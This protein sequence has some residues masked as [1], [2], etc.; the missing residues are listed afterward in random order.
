MP[1]SRAPRID[2]S[3]AASISE[4]PTGMRIL[5]VKLSSLGDVVHTLPV[6]QDIARARPGA[7]IEWA[8]EPAFA[9]LVRRAAGIGEV[10][11][12]PLRRW[13]QAW[14]TKGVRAEC[15]ALRDRLRAQRYDAVIDLQGLTKSALVAR[16]ANGPRYG[17][18][19]A[20]DGS[21]FEW[22]A[23]WLVDR[24]ISVPRRIHALDR[25]RLVAARALGYEV[26]GPPDF[27]LQAHPPRMRHE[28]HTVAFVH[29]SSRDDKL[30]PH[31]AWVR[32]G[33][34]FTA[35]GW[36]IALPQ[37]NEIEQTRAELIAAGWEF[38]ENAQLEV[39]PSMKIDA[40]IDRLAGTQGV[41]GV[42][43]GLS[44]IAVALKLP[45]VQIYN[46]PTAWRTG[47]LPEHGVRH[48]IALEG[49]P[50]PTLDAV[51]AAWNRVIEA[52]HA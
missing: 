7:Q 39:W 24:A 12:V 17:L 29:G 43:S 5:I 2:E 38:V 48:Q 34:K 20:T 3:G 42:D 4:V 31:D 36:R 26:Q 33:K 46:Y 49:R 13:R 28:R 15:L 32:L 10:I 6:V 11:E 30:W 1:G 22:P 44:H 9:P 41:V 25:G 45:V 37:G 47:P 16:A 35:D 8:V 21:A 50:T 18:A 19:H 51:W 23:R 52:A 27:G 40:V 14:W